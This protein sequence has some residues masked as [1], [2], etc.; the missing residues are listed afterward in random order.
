MAV[1][2]PPEHIRYRVRRPAVY[3]G[4]WHL[5]SSS[6]ALTDPWRKEGAG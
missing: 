4:W 5:T 2:K 1:G 3:L 6:R